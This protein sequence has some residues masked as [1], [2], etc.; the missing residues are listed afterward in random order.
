MQTFKFIDNKTNKLISVSR[1]NVI[2]NLY[3]NKISIPQNMTNKKLHDFKVQISKIDNYIPLYDI[4]SDNLYIFKKKYVYNNVF[5]KYFRFPTIKFIN[6]IKSSI[7]EKTN[8]LKTTK[9][10]INNIKLIILNDQLKRY[11]MMIRFLNNFD[12][13]TLLDTYITTLYDINELGSRITLCRKPSFT[14]LISDIIPYYTKMEIANMALNMNLIKSKNKLSNNDYRDLCTQIS[15]NDINNKN[16]VAHHKYI[17]ENK[18][19]GLIQF[20]SINGFMVLNNYLRFSNIYNKHIESIVLTLTNVIINA[21]KLD[22]DYYLYRFIANDFFIS[23][24]LVG[25]VFVEKG[26]LSTTRNPFYTQDNLV[27]GWNL[28]KIK[29]NKN[30]PMLCI[31][32]VSNF[33]SE[34]E[35]IFAPNTKLKLISKNNKHIYYH[36]DEKIQNSIQNIYE[37]EII[38]SYG[39]EPSKQVMTEIITTNQLISNNPSNINIINFATLDNTRIK[40]YITLKEKMNDFVVTYTNEFNQFYTKLKDTLILIT[41][42]SYNSSSIYRNYYKIRTNSGIMF[43]CMNNNHQLFIIEFADNKMI[44]NYGSKFN[45]YLHNNNFDEYPFLLLISQI[46]YYFNIFY[47]DIY[48]NYYNCDYF[49]TNINELD[50]QM[51]FTHYN[52]IICMDI[53]DYIVNKKKRF[54]NLNIPANIIQPKFNYSILDMFEHIYLN[55]KIFGNNMIILKQLFTKIY[56]KHINKSDKITIKDFYVWLC[57][58]NCYFVNDFIKLISA[59]PEFAKDNPFINDYYVFYPISFLYNNSLIP[60]IPLEQTPN[61][62]YTFKNMLYSRSNDPRIYNYEY[63]MR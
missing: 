35:I 17:I 9:Q 26:F 40:D 19:V 23:N 50:Y 5:K 54:D 25:D 12:P 4:F 60:N 22:K 24:L 39:Y 42:E 1:N 56:K 18:M 37:F 63:N 29:V 61:K 55:K 43:Y 52:G 44:I 10:Q 45:T 3:K 32:S 30:I 51:K 57:M 62:Y 6:Q 59:M 27:F 48:C 28:L 34:E 20:Y 2:K 41:V 36:P 13:D 15:Q 33:H 53:Y 16:L 47:V 11:N 7:S 49:S 58:N 21:P 46:A 14:P 8:L 31:E 38:E